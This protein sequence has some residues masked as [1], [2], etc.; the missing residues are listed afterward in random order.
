[1]GAVTLT[2]IG[3]FAFVAMRV[4]QPGMALLYGDLSVADANAII[5]DLETRGVRY[6][7]RADGQT[8]LA[9]K[10]MVAR[11]RLDF[12]GKG[13]PTGGGVGYEIFD[14]GDAFSSTSFVQGINQLRALEGELSRT[15]RSLSRVQAARVHLV[16]PERKLFERDREPPRASIVLKLAGDLD[17]AQVRA[18][19][20]LV[21]SAV[22]GLKPDKISIVDERG[23]LLADGA[24]GDT[25][26]SLGLDEKQTN[27]ERR[28]QGQLEEIVARIVGQGRARVQ[29]TAEIDANR[30]ENRSET[31]DPESRVVRSTQTRTESQQTSEPREAV[32]VGNELPGANQAQQGQNQPQVTRDA[33]NKNEEVTNFEISRTSRTEVIEGGRV[34]RLSVAVLV[35]GTYGRD[36]AGETTYQERPQAELDRIGAL[37]RT[38]IGFDARRGDQIEIV[39]LRFAE[40]PQLVGEK[41]DSSFASLFAFGRED[42]MRAIELAVVAILVLVVLL[43]VVRPLVK[44]MLAP[45]AKGQRGVAGLLTAGGANAEAAPASGSPGLGLNPGAALAASR[46]NNTMQMLDIAKL[47]GQMQ[48]RSVERVGELVRNNPEETVSI[49][50]EWVHQTS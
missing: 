22:E 13:I 44:R 35:D 16:L 2:L 29:V 8:I 5:R 21:A 28:L 19:R 11:L 33:T 3:F 30:I 49:L 10:D 27:V 18:V 47:S 39:N 41:P 6:E 46:Q 7:T 45:E 15:I 23:R 17:A 50:R 38:A 36:A 48:T 1:M 32:S 20:H 25:T 34:K 42:V 14:K 26:A 43:T 37:V 31:F 24:Q 40:A 9:Q 12:A 4:A